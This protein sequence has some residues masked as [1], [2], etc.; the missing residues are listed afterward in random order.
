[1]I[2]DLKTSAGAAARLGPPVKVHGRDSV[3]LLRRPVCG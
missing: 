2:E 3:H 1:M